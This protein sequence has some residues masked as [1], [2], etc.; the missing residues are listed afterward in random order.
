[1]EAIRRDPAAGDL[2]ATAA[3]V[4]SW[5]SA[6]EQ[7]DLLKLWVEAYARS[8]IDPTGPWG[9]YAAETVHVWL[10]LL[11]SCHPSRR[12]PAAHEIADCTAVLALLRERVARPARHGRRR[13]HHTG[14]RLHPPQLGGGRW[15]DGLIPG[16]RT[17][18]AGTGHRPSRR[19]EPRDGE[20]EEVG[21]TAHERGEPAAQPWQLVTAGRGL[22]HGCEPGRV[23]A[24]EHADTLGAEVDD[25]RAPS[26]A[27]SRASPATHRPSPCRRHAGTR[28]R[29]PATTAE[30]GGV[31][32]DGDPHAGARRT[33][34]PA[35]SGGSS[36]A[37]VGGSGSALSP[38]RRRLKESAA[39]LDAW[40]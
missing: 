33:G 21:V 23:L 11:A 40:R 24:V 12:R 9:G 13:P 5:L 1:M 14:G 16:G 20:L 17:G 39:P 4:W 29:G 19:A 37:G 26:L 8:L 25:R 15:G 2:L 27:G 38:L 36:H 6:P 28:R 31:E 32:P 34:N 30:H 35:R 18:G 10:D 7:R 22:H 3:R